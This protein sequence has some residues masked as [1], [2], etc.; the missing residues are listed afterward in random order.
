M[1]RA[2]I[3]LGLCA[4]LAAAVMA[5]TALADPFEGPPICTSAGT[6]ISGSYGNL[7]ITGNAYVKSG[8]TLSVAGNLT[9][10]KGSCLDA[11]T[12]GT[13]NVAGNVVVG[14]G[15]SLPSGA[16][17]ARRGRSRRAA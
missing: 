17:P 16:A 13:V 1:I 10:A 6:P 11:F 4:V 9:L 3:L 15:G 12:L 8:T 14:K 5:P 7:T 2:R